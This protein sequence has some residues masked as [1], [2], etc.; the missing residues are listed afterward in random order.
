M[1]CDFKNIK[2]YNE[3]LKRGNKRADLIAHDPQF[4]DYPHPTR[5]VEM[6]TA[7]EWTVGNPY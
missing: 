7:S 1:K 5:V 2:Y 6:E 4:L 3:L